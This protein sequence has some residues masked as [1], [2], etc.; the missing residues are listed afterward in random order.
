MVAWSTFHPGVPPV[1]AVMLIYVAVFLRKA[2]VEILLFK[3]APDLTLEVVSQLEQ[4]EQV[5]MN[6]PLGLPLYSRGASLV[7]KVDLLFSEVVTAT[8]T[9]EML[10]LVVALARRG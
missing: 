7:K 6:K 3:W 8:S 10:I 4:D 9:E 2:R 5:P 1:K